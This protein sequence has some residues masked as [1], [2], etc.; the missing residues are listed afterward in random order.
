[1]RFCENPLGTFLREF[2][3]RGVLGVWKFEWCLNVVHLKP[4]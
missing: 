4:Y 2:D 3:S 1:M